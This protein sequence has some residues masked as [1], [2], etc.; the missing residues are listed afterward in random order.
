MYN[1]Y[2]HYR[3]K[4][5]NIEEGSIVYCIYTPYDM[6]TPLTIVRIIELPPDTVHVS[7]VHLTD[8]P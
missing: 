8:S 7:F 6:F 3:Q 4:N 2:P 5:Y 1:F